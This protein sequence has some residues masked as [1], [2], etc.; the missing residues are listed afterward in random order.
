MVL[1]QRATLNSEERARDFQ[2]LAS[3]LGRWAPLLPRGGA[4]DNAIAMDATLTPGLRIDDRYELLGRIADGTFGEV[5]RAADLRLSGKAVAVKVLKAEFVDRPDV[6]ARFESEADALARLA[7]PN[8]VAVLDRGAWSGSRYIVTELAEG[9]TLAALLDEARRQGAQ[10]PLAMVLALFDQVCAAVEAAHLVQVPG[11]IVHRDLKPDNIVARQL[12]SGEWS[13]KVLDFG[14]AQLGG[15]HGTQTGSLLGTPLYMAP[16]QAMGQVQGVGPW[17][18]VFAL[19]T[20]LIE[21]LTLRATPQGEETW[22]ATTLRCNGQVAPLLSGL[23]GD[24]SPALWSVVARALQPDGAQRFGHAGL[25]RV[26][27]RATSAGDASAQG[28]PRTVAI[29]SFQGSSPNIWTQGSV[30]PLGATPTSTAFGPPVAGSYSAPPSPYGAPG[31]G[32]FGP[33]HPMPFGGTLPPAHRSG[34]GSGFSAVVIGGLG[35]ALLA[36]MG[37][38]FMLRRPSPRAEPVVAVAAPE[39]R[40]TPYVNPTSP[41]R[42]SPTSGQVFNLTPLPGSPSRGPA[43]AR[44]TIIEISDFQCPFCGRA[45]A[46]LERV[47]ERYPR[48]VRFVWVHYPLAFHNNAMP[49]AE[50]AV[51]AQRQLGDDGFW[52]MHDMLFAN[53]RAL[54]GPD[55]ANYAEAVG[56]SA[57]PFRLAM[58]SRRHQPRVRADMANVNAVMSSIGTPSFLIN[59]R[60]LRGAQPYERFTE[61]IDAALAGR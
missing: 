53:P 27:L 31:V 6:V 29:P 59:S 28:A 7:H 47:R 37:A 21:M 23:R 15:R 33:P 52:R 51:E 25:F 34:G 56:L 8:V 30:A 36:A 13:V 49:A 17:T 16:E 1:H 61:A 26:A 50:A 19:A 46:T 60:L 32:S 35:M 10:P 5:W 11:P 38:W 24:V 2:P 12:P 54:T 45:Q 3:P 39:P 43:D 44:V 58:S 42:P 48:D 9:R 57:G 55:L 41:T 22:W 40:P 20:L 18:D 4:C 14:I